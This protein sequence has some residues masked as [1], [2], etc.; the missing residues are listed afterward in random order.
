MMSRVF[1]L[2]L[3][4][5]RCGGSWLL[6][7]GDE[8]RLRALVAEHIVQAD[9]VFGRNLDS[10]LQCYQRAY[11]LAANLTRGKVIDMS[12]RDDWSLFAE[13]ANGVGYVLQNQG[14]VDSCF[15]YHRQCLSISVPLSIDTLTAWALNNIG[16]AFHRLGDLDSALLYYRRSLDLRIRMGSKEMSQNTMNNIAWVYQ[17][18]GALDSA[19]MYMRRVLAINEESGDL[20]S[21]SNT[22]HSLGANAYQRGQYAKALNLHS[23]SLRIREETGDQPGIATSTGEL[24]VVYEAL[25]DYLSAL[26]F[27]RRSRDMVERRGGEGDLAT[28]VNNMGLIY[29][30]M[31]EKDSARLMFKL[32]MEMHE[33]VGERDGM[34]L[35]MA[36]LGSVLDNQ[37]QHVKALEYL[38]R[39]V[40]LRRTTGN[41]GGLAHSLYRLGAYHSKHGDNWVAKA[42]LTEALE[43]SKMSGEAGTLVGIA[44]ELSIVYHR[45]GS[46]AEAYAMLALHQA[47]KDSI[48]SPEA[49]LAMIRQQVEYARQEQN[50]ADSLTHALELQR[51]NHDKAQ[52]E[53]RADRNQKRAI[54]FGAS[55]LALGLLGGGLWLNRM[56]ILTKHERDAERLERNAAESEVKALR[57]QIDP[58]F[59][60]NVLAGLADSV[61]SNDKQQTYGHVTKIAKLMRAVL[62]SSRETVV[63]LGSDMAVLRQYIDLERDQRGGTFDYTIDIDPAIDQGHTLIPPMLFQPFVENAIRHGL[64]TKESQGSLTLALRMDGEQLRIVVQDDG[65]GMRPKVENS[66]HVSI[67]TSLTRSR[68]AM[69]GQQQGAPAGFDYVDVPIGVRVEVFMPVA[70]EPL[71]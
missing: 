47:V 44:K 59:L 66:G 8:P 19:E 13:S 39:S 4:W 49:N 65:V 18:R 55:A 26:R 51:A 33:K 35:A 6:A 10:A 71:G 57:A 70:M 64:G 53:L 48:R 17:H 9:T 43:L 25:G 32:S 42:M 12:T 63:P 7:Q 46:V 69:W 37:G 31:N 29:A 21:M 14:R 23:R 62:E 40:E 58:H 1:V 50:A 45:L 24:A 3:L 36:N 52:A 15:K 60:N 30:N 11:V 16:I 27:L 20:R 54:A 22:L 38:Q 61:L 56:R 5:F 34:A 28:V 68:L 2:L 41:Q 67:G